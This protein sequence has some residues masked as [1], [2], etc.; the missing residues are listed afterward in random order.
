MT[1]LIKELKT[2]NGRISLS[3]RMA[4]S[5]RKKK[6]CKGV[7]TDLIRKNT[8]LKKFKLVSH[9]VTDAGNLCYSVELPKTKEADEM[10]KVVRHLRRDK[11]HLLSVIKG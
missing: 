7:V 9:K 8:D 10:L 4:S 5:L 1:S 2:K 3:K 11:A 6:R